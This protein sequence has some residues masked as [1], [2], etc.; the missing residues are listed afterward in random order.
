[1]LK[2]ALA[3]LT[4]TLLAAPDLA[5]RFDTR[6]QVIDE[7]FASLDG[8]R[9]FR[10]P[11][12]R[13]LDLRAGGAPMMVAVYEQGPDGENL[14]ASEEGEDVRVDRI[15]DLDR[16]GNPELVIRVGNGGSCL[17]CS[18]LA[19][20]GARRGQ[21][22]NLSPDVTLH[23][24]VDADGDGRFEAVAI[25]TSLTGSAGLPPVATP[26]VEKLYTLAKSGFVDD[27]RRFAKYHWR[28]LTEIRR[29]LE[30]D[31]EGRTGF[32]QV[33]LCLELYFEHEI[34]GKKNDGL[35]IATWFLRQLEVK[36]DRMTAVA[37]ERARLALEDRVLGRQN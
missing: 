17:G 3:A 29:A 10:I 7:Q 20:Y 35:E 33:K 27:D 36:S 9:R 8:S 32:T 23:D 34:L 12:L 28:R 2:T 30:Q 6:Y 16:D 14:V 26:R 22:K 18:S 11:T 1:M 21:I 25:A 37:A 15:H 4:V 13:A 24:L 19:I 31:P 5:P